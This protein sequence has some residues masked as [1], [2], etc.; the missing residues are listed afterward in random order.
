[1]RQLNKVGLASPQ[2][3]I[4]GPGSTWGE[5]LQKIS[6]DKFTLI[7]GQCTSVGVG[8]FILGGGI[9][10]V[11]SSERYGSA[12]MQVERYTMIDAM[13]RILLVSRDNTSVIDPVTSKATHQLRQDFGLFEAMR[14]AGSSFGI[15]TEFLYKI[16]PRPET[17]P[18]IALI[19]LEGP[20][21]IRN[22]ER[23]SQDG[24]FHI[25]WFVPYAFRDL[26][27]SVRF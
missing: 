10:V 5:V 27:L 3:A 14:G 11:G 22:L 21:D 4:L 2:L 18:I 17:L 26:S 24:R 19:Y 9:N 23:A 12:A 8:G 15:V 25:S 6:P 7:H 1:M 20:G 13:G 16:Y